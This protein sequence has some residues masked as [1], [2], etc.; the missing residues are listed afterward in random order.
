MTYYEAVSIEQDFKVR[1]QFADCCGKERIEA[2]KQVA[3]K[4]TPEQ[5]AEAYSVIKKQKMD[6]LET[7]EALFVLAIHSKGVTK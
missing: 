1:M 2:V 3:E 4:Y 5:L 6:E 7:L